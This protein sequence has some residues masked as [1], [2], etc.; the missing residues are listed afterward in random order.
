MHCP[1]LKNLVLSAY[2]S[3]FHKL[4]DPFREGLKIERPGEMRET[5]KIAGDVIA[6][7]LKALVKHVVANRPARHR[8]SKFSNH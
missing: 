5:P 8:S 6:H 4:P 3:S 2:P 7:L 1:Q